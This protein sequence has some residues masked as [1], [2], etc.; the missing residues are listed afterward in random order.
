MPSGPTAPPAPRTRALDVL[1]VVGLLALL[2]IAIPV[3][4][5]SHYGAMGIPRSDDWSYLLTMYRWIEDGKLT[6]NGWVSMTL[7]GQVLL[8][9]PIALATGRNITLVQ[10]F[11]ATLGLVGLLGVVWIGRQVVRPAW[12]AVFV[13]AT[14]AAGPLWGPLAPTFMTDVPAFAF[15]MLSLSAAIVAFRTRPLSLKWLAIAVALGFVGVSIRQYAV[16]P[17]VAILLVAAGVLLATRDWRRLRAV[18]V[19]GAIFFLATVVLLAWWSG[20][21]DSKSLAP[22]VPDAHLVSAL[23]IKDAGFLRLT[24]L[25]LLP[26][27]VL[28]GPVLIARRAWEASRELTAVLTGGMAVWLVVMYARVPRTP[29]VGN[30]VA[31]EGVLSTDVLSGN[32]PDVIP[33]SLF[34]LLVVLG[35]AA[36]ILVVLAA[37]P[38]LTDLPRRWR[39]RDFTPSDPAAAL[40]GWVIAGFATAYSLAIVTG[41][42]VYDRYAL[43]VLPLVALLVLRATKHDV[44]T[45]ATLRPRRIGAGIAIALMFVLGIA[46]TTDSASF[47]GA[48]WKVSELA[49]EAG[50]KPLQVGGGFEWLSYHREHGPL[51]RWD[52]AKDR[53]VKLKRYATP[54]VNVLINPSARSRRIVAEVES[55]ALT[56][57]DVPV[58]AIRNRRPCASGGRAQLGNGATVPTGAAD[59][60]ASARR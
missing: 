11:T 55:G 60:A 19:I 21:P 34:D 10:L 57:A 9:A 1:L 48:R 27:V 22:S 29:F 38:F 49:T 17:V 8:A 16:I 18:G 50:Y 5:A 24:G 26:V 53:P 2:G 31:R 6:F 44:R 58:V 23:L 7:M 41:L 4:I 30:Y 13:A 14:I 20:L 56:R 42:P 43:P 32:R 47:D 33:R 12:W 28:A 15:Q 35:S 39:E 40:L 46:Y 51:Y 45:E 3:A 37:V 54:C 36:G 25:L 59:R 52:F